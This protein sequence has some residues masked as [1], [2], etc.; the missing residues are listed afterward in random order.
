MARFIR[1]NLG[2]A[3]PWHISRF[4]PQYKEQDLPPTDVATLAK[5]RAIGLEEG[6]HYVYSGNVPG[7][8][9]EKTYCPRCSHLLVDRVG[10]S[11]RTY[12]IKEGRCPSC[13]YV[14]EGVEM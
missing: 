12:A 8:P 13:D 11:R 4:Y 7:D 5:A 9:G 14:V 6:L 1:D 10:Y 3:T 2:A